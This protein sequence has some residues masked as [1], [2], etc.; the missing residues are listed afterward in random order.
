MPT[1]FGLNDKKIVEAVKTG[2]LAEEVLDQAVERILNIVYRFAE[3]RDATAVF[4]READHAFAR[5]V[6]SEC[7]VLL[8]NDGILPL[9][10]ER[11]AAFIGAFAEKPRYQGGG[12]SH[13]NASQTESALEMAAGYPVVYAKGYD[14]KED[15]V[16]EELVAEAV[17]VAKE[18]EVAVIFAGLPDAFESEGYDRQHRQSAERLWMCFTAR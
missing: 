12:S 4:D 15:Q 17:R 5:K 16:D 10:E 7:I 11:K 13:I 9:A 3:N 8:K 1:S 14:T 18:A 6:A 2:T